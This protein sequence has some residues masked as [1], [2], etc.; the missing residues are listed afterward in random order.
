MALAW[1]HAVVAICVVFVPTDAV[2]AVGIPVKAGESADKYELAAV[3]AA[4]PSVPPPPIFNVL[5]SLPANVSV[6]LIVKVFG[7]APPTMVNPYAAEANVSPLI[8][9]VTAMLLKYFK[10]FL[11]PSM[12][13][14]SN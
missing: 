5:P 9:P 1:A 3:K 8:D 13:E 10:F 2:G 4:V 14:R 11:L 7:A 12:R 6:L